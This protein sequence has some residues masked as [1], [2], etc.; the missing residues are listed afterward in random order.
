MVQAERAQR[1][2]WASAARS[3]RQSARRSPWP[4]RGRNGPRRRT[5]EL[6]AWANRARGWFELSVSLRSRSAIRALLLG[7]LCG[8]GWSVLFADAATAQNRPITLGTGGVT[9]VYYPVG[10][11]ICRLVNRARKTH[12]LRCAVE[13]TPGSVFN[14]VALRSGDFDLAITQSDLEHRAVRGEGEFASRGPDQNLRVLF[15]IHAEP[16]TVVARRSS[17]IRSFVD[18]R[19]KRVSIGNAGSGQRSTMDILMAALGWKS[20]DFALALELRASELPQALCDDKIDAMVFTTGHPS[21]AIHQTTQNC[22]AVIVP[23]EGAPIETL[24]RTDPSFAP[25]VIRGHLYRGNDRDVPTI[26][27]RAVLVASSRL[28]DGVVYEVVKAVFENL[29]AFREAHPALAALD[30]ATMVA[31]TL[32]EPRHPGAAKYFKEKGLL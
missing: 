14:L 18:L 11:T 26:G 1:P 30:R 16:F 3:E 7:V 17:G 29:D 20:K 23:L 12:G 6:S 25:L 8:P 10:G 22:D 19:H 15:S 27:A 21:A 32:P 31:K 2:L 5:T 13:S 4:A 9:G 28:S 24:L